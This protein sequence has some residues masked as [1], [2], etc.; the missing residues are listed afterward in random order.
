M[1]PTVGRIVHYTSLGSADER[2]PPETQAALITSAAPKPAAFMRSTEESE[3][4]A[5][6]RYRAR[7]Q[8][9]NNYEV[10]L[11]VFYGNDHGSGEFAMAKVPFASEAKPGCWNW[12]PRE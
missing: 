5:L 4:V 7:V 8:D 3:G 10:Y 9:E 12:P 11:R 2:F 6:E 1:K